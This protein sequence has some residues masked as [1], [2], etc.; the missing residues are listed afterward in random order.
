MDSPAVSG[1]TELVASCVLH[2][3]EENQTIESCWAIHNNSPE[4]SPF[5]DD[6]PY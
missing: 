3:G 1:Y 4:L 6:F 2:A 5:G